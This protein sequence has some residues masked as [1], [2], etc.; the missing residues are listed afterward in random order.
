MAD[1]LKGDG[2]GLLNLADLYASRNG[3]GTYEDNSSEAIFAI[4]CLDDPWAIGPRKIHAA[5]PEFEEASPTLGV[6]APPGCWP[7]AR[8]R[9]R[10][11]HSHDSTSVRPAAPIVVIGT[12][13]DPATPYEWAEASAAQLESG[14]LGLAL[15]GWAHGL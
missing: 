12:T 8:G 3:D 6:Q 15:R 11:R 10:A 9:W 14:V 7:A 5:V 4:N 13:R 1:A 2:A